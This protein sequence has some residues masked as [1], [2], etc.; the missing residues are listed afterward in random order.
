VP[1]G[2]GA[3]CTESTC[4]KG[5]DRLGPIRAEIGEADRQTPKAR[6]R[7]CRSINRTADTRIFSRELDRLWLYFSVSYRGVRC[8]ICNKMQDCAQLVHAKLTQGFLGTV[9]LF[10]E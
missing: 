8:P 10:N 9:Y 2:R 3:G 6:Q 1:E 5:E 4:P 7:S